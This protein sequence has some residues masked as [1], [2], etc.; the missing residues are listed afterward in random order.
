M[1]IVVVVWMGGIVT[2]AYEDRSQRVMEVTLAM[3]GCLYDISFWVD[4]GASVACH[5][6]GSSL[7]ASTEICD[8][9]SALESLSRRNTFKLR[10][11]QKVILWKPL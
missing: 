3:G 9:S 10:C 11:H 1:V 7:N 5:I 4:K 6:V 8:D 2:T